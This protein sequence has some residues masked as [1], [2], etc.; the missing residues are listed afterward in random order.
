M[1]PLSSFYKIQA[2][3]EFRQSLDKLRR[4]LR[5]KYGNE[6]CVSQVATIKS[7]ISTTLTTTPYVAPISER[8]LDLG[9]KEYRQWPVDSHNIV[10]YSV[11]E[12]LKQVELLAIMDARQSI[13]K[14][15]YEILLLN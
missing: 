5:R 11:N 12:D 4:F 3:V 8:L 6:F 13:E 2:S 15:L 10:F 1:K 9:I 7:A 14:L